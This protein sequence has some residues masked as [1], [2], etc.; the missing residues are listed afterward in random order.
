MIFKKLDPTSSMYLRGFDRRGCVATLNNATE[1]SFQV[2]GIFSD[3]AD[4][5]V[6]MMYDADDLYG[7]LTTSKYL[8]DFNLNGVKLSFD[9]KTTNCFN[10]ISSRFPSVPWNAIS[11]IKR[12]GTSGTIALP[13]TATK[14]GTK[15]KSDIF[16]I[17]GTPT[18]FD[19]IQIYYLSNILFDL[20]TITTGQTLAQVVQAMVDLI[21]N[22]D[23]T[24]ALIPALTAAVGANTSTFTVSYAAVGLDGNLVTLEA[25]TKSGSNTIL[26]PSGPTSLSGGTDPD[27]I[28]IEIDFGAL[29]IYDV[30]QLWLTIAPYVPY[31]LGDDPGLVFNQTEFSWVATNWIVEDLPN[32]TPLK[33]AGPLS[34]T[35]SALD[36]GVVYVGGW[37]I[38]SGFFYHGF[39]KASSNTS[40]TVT[41]TYTN[42]H[43]HDLYLGTA[44]ASDR[45]VYNINLD[46]V[47]HGTINMALNVA[48]QLI[49]RRL[50]VQNVIPGTHT[51]ILTITS[52]ALACY[53][54]YIQAVVAA[55]PIDP[56]E[57]YENLSAALD[58]DT[59]QTYN[60]SPA[61][62]IFILRQLGLRGN[63]DFYRGVLFSEVRQRFGG[64][65]TSC[66]VTISGTWATGTGF[67]DGDSVTMNISGTAFG[68]TIFPSDTNITIA[69]RLAHFINFI[70]VGVRAV[71]TGD[72]TT[73]VLTITLISPING[74]TITAAKSLGATGSIVLAGD[75]SAGNEGVWQISPNRLS[76]SITEFPLNKAFID[77][78]ADFSSTAEFYGLSITLSVSQELLAPPDLN[79]SGG[80]WIQRY[81]DG[82]TVLT[83]TGF[84]SWGTGYIA[85]FSVAA[86][87]TTIVS[88]GHGYITGNILH[89]VGVDTTYPITVINAN[90]FSIVGTPTISAGTQIFISLQTSQCNFNPSTVTAYLSLVFFQICNYVDTVQF[91]EI[92]WWFF[93]G[94]AGP[95]MAYYD[96]YTEAQ[97]TAI[98]GRGV[99]TF[100]APTNDP[101][102]NNYADTN[103]LRS[104]LMKH[105]H[106]M[107]SVVRAGT[108]RNTKF[109]LLCPYDVNWPTN[110]INTEWPFN[111]GG[112]L[113]NYVNILPEF[114][115]P[116]GD[117]DQIMMEALAW[118][119]SYRTLDNT[120]STIDF[121]STLGSWPK[122]L[123]GYLI[124]V[125]NGGC[126]WTQE[127]K[128][129]IDSGI[130][131]IKLWAI[132]HII[133]FSWPFPIP[134]IADFK[135]SKPF[136]QPQTTTLGYLRTYMNNL[137]NVPPPNTGGGQ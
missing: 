126:P 71:V 105:I 104:L 127:I 109:E 82:T 101:S 77:W 76:N 78:I 97:S 59:N 57:V 45:G 20:T 48:S 4:F 67:G 21:N 10:P 50:L 22:Y 130:A 137:I 66:T 98:L 46:G 123:I 113:N 72:T 73:A 8:P 42:G 31:A 44:L 27:G 9:L 94:G 133:L 128:I 68:V 52:S 121:P 28:L 63:I 88:T 85:S 40:D 117:I 112:A 136:Y 14:G 95:S 119:T 15:A 12:D 93:S 114:L 33:I 124:P 118:G 79:T 41:I 47:D 110:Y 51:L 115:N 64:S 84:G 1:T 80:S 36:T 131:Q 6:L 29:G 83:A 58:F 11:Y 3:M 116:N 54:D 2:S 70:F 39:S 111:I 49:T 26:T 43:V 96:A 129:A 103:L 89:I 62:A 69:Q 35:I 25:E 99:A 18:T 38:E 120:Q 134:L 34:T 108:Q 16:V 91:G 100:T 56:V 75:L 13:V 106:T 55:D 61:R 53:F 24:T 122:N 86:G 5:A 87:V 81:N 17:S 65:F 19:R 30:R 74:F 23:Y 132:D 135:Y 92:L 107:R 37:G 90:S 32:I 60:L 125:Q 102:L 7:H